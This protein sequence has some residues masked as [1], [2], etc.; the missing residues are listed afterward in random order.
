MPKWKDYEE[1]ATRIQK[2]LASQAKVTHNEVIEGIHSKSPRQIDI[3]IRQNVGQFNLFIAIDCKDHKDRI[4]VKEVEQF[5]ELIKDVGANKGAIISASDFTSGAKNRAKAASIE[6]YRLID[7]DDHAWQAIVSMP[8]V[9]EM[10]AIKAF[11]FGFRSSTPG[12]FRMHTADINNTI[13]YR[14]NGSAIDTIS[15]ILRTKWNNGQIPIE[16]GRHEDIRLSNLP[17]CIKY[18]DALYHVDVFAHVTI[19]A[20]MYFGHLPIVEMKGLQDSI[21]G[22]IIS[23]GFTTGAMDVMEVEKSWTKI[24]SMEDLAIQPGMSFVMADY[25]ETTP[26]PSEK[27]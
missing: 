7:T 22:G 20:N 5:M 27:S 4:D 10:R 16:P 25:Y 26:P 23:R 17:T 19:K 2:I 12:P 8:V 6:L 15:N 11:S 14:E 24:E 18:N 9:C 1:L 13:L 21:E 3:A